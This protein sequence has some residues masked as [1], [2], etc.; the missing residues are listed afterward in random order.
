MTSGRNAVTHNGDTIFNDD[1]SNIEMTAPGGRPKWYSRLPSRPH[2]RGGLNQSIIST[3]ILG[4]DEDEEV[5]PRRE[6]I[7]VVS[8]RKM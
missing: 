2:T 4:D 7:N 1:S 8:G 6:M 3:H 5:T